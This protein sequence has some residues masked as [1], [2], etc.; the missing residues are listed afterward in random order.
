MWDRN[1]CKCNAECDYECMCEWG[2]DEDCIARSPLDWFVKRKKVNM[3]M[4]EELALN[5]L[6]NLHSANGNDFN[7]P[8][9]DLCKQCT[10][11]TGISNMSFV[12]G[13]KWLREQGYANTIIDKKDN[14]NKLCSITTKG[15]NYFE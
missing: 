9:M 5:V 11:Q 2:I 15:I 6:F 12:I 4:T 7:I 14:R 3:G 8:I 10:S 1:K 13:I